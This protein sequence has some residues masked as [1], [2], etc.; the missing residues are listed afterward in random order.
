M[1]KPTSESKLDAFSMESEFLGVDHRVKNFDALSRV[2]SA[3][4]IVIEKPWNVFSKC[5]MKSNDARMLKI[6]AA[7]KMTCS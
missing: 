3:T 6:E 1:Y 5:T 4:S 2:G 7:S